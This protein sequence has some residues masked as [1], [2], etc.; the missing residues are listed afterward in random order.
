MN[1]DLLKNFMI[2][3]KEAEAAKEVEILKE[4]GKHLYRKITK[5]DEENGIIVSS[6][7]WKDTFFYNSGEITRKDILR[8]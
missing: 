5:I 4:I 3:K 8:K 6:K 2:K 1:T 7:K